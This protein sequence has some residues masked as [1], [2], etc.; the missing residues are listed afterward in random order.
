MMVFKAPT[1]EVVRSVL[2]DG[3]DLLVKATNDTDLTR[4]IESLN[5]ARGVSH[6]SDALCCVH[7][8]PAHLQTKPRRISP[9]PNP[10]AR[11]EGVTVLECGLNSCLCLCIA[12]HTPLRPSPIR[13]AGVRLLESHL[14]PNPSCLRHGPRFPRSARKS[15]HGVNG[16]YAIRLGGHGA[17]RV[18][19]RTVRRSVRSPRNPAQERLRLLL[20]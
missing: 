4:R 20:S 17:P 2:G 5:Q 14:L 10:P 6:G 18:R 19:K 12:T 9:S 8:D 11:L 13:E 16:C 1:A 7:D 15:F 3:E